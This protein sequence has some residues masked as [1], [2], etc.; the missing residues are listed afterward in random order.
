[1]PRLYLIRH[2][3]LTVIKGHRQDMTVDGTKST[4][5]LTKKLLKTLVGDVGFEPTTR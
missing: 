1:M 5:S 4:N 3:E 2:A